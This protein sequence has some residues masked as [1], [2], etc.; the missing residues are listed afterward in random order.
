MVQKSNRGSTP[1]SQNFSAGIRK[2]M[3]AQALV[4]MPELV[5]TPSLGVS[6]ESL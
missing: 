6:L 2:P 1:T 3:N 4:G 5:Q